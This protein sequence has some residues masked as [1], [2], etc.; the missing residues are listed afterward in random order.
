MGCVLSSGRGEVKAYNEL[1]SLLPLFPLE[2]V[3]FPGVP[4]PLHVFEPRYKEMIGECLRAESEFGIVRVSKQGVAAI[5]CT[6]AIVEV[7]K[8][9]DDGRMDILTE[10]RRRFEVVD[11]NQERSFLRA[12]VMFLEDEPDAAPVTEAQQAIRLYLDLLALADVEAQ[13]PPEPGPQLSYLITA[14]LP[15]E[16]DFKQQLLES[17]SESERIGVIV[18]YYTALIPR[19]TH[20]MKTRKKAGGNGH[21]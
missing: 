3:L 4:L 11:I 20:A 5:G 19:L 9:Y 18:E 14:G 17:R 6:A 15:L 13:N 8:K 1:V 2:L 21:G 12:D 16:L 7:V 10:G